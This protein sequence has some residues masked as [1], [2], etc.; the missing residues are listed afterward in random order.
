MIQP[1][2]T[3]TTRGGIKGEGCTTVKLLREDKLVGSSL[4][5]LI[6]K[7]GLQINRSNNN[8]S[9]AQTSKHCNKALDRRV[10]R[11]DAM[12]GDAGKN[13]AHRTG[14]GAQPGVLC[15]SVQRDHRDHGRG[16]V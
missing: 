3:H 1:H 8:D 9:N 15:G 4:V 2:K 6:N 12:P 13:A 16:V 11:H 10:W 14:A 7:I 5:I